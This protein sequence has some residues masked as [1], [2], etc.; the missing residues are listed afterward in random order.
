MRRFEAFLLKLR[1]LPAS[2]WV[3][4]ASLFLIVLISLSVLNRNVPVHGGDAEHFA[5][6]TVSKIHWTVGD[7]TWEFYRPD[8]NHP[9]LPGV[10]SARVQRKLLA[11]SALNLKKMKP[12][13]SPQV[14]VR[15]EFGK[16]EDH[17]DGGYRDGRFVWI[18]GKLAGLG[19]DLTDGQK[20]VFLEG[21]FAF[22]PL[23]W[24]WCMTRPEQILF[25]LDSYQWNLTLKQKHWQLK[26][27]EQEVPIDGAWV[28][29]WLGRAC[30]VEL[31]A[32]RDLAIES[33][34]SSNGLLRINFHN[35]MQTTWRF[36]DSWLT[37]DAERGGHAAA[38]VK[39]LQEVQDSHATTKK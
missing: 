12:P 29:K 38:F 31:R 11:I 30:Q 18:T 7:K 10:P 20:E 14:F 25:E 2:A 34:P 23:Q 13:V 1:K 22:D 27:L 8:R 39:T 36:Y 33:L 24:S 32:F 21:R 6:N 15:L 5:P 37:L 35:G 28:E 3:L 17:W 9:W 4:V 16:P 26:I 19:A